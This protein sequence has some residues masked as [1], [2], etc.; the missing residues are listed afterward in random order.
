M[1]GPALLL[2]ILNA[3]FTSSVL[4][5]TSPR[6][7]SREARTHADGCGFSDFSALPLHE[8][9]WA[10]GIWTATGGILQKEPILALSLPLAMSCMYTSRARVKRKYDT[11]PHLGYLTDL[12]CD[13]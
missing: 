2:H 11:G 5:P 3:L 7:Y 13:G 12:C 9:A 6:V 10:S 8:T 1:I 4:F